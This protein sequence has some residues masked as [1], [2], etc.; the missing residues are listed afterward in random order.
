MFDRVQARL[1][2]EVDTLEAWL[3]QADLLAKD[4]AVLERAAGQPRWAL[5][6]YPDTGVGVGRPTSS[7]GSSS[8]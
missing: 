6:R 7:P 2:W 4:R 8:G 5:E 1:A 3:Q